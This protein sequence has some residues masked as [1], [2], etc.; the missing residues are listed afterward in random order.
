MS[1]PP[2]QRT[3]RR[4]VLSFRQDATGLLR[5]NGS[6]L[7]VASEFRL[8]R[9]RAAPFAMH[10]PAEMIGGLPPRRHAS[11]AVVLGQNLWTVPLAL[12]DDADVE[13]GVEEFA[14]GELPEPVEGEIEVQRLTAG[15]V[16]TSDRRSTCSLCPHLGPAK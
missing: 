14:G 4:G 12:R 2:T 11:L 6:W 3:W 7:L 13:S 1:P 5:C 16:F 9:C 10:D 8:R 15:G